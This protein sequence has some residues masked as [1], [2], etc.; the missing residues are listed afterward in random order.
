MKVS[1]QSKGFTLV[2]L[3][4]VIAII[5]LLAA[6]LF[7]VFNSVR[8]K[9]AQTVCL[10]NLKQLGSAIQMYVQDTGGFIPT[11]CISRNNP[12]NPPGDTTAPGQITWDASI[13]AYMK[14]SEIVKC[15]SNPNTNGKRARAY[16]IA[17]YTQRPVSGSPSTAWVPLRGCY[18][19]EIPAP[20]QT[21]LL[22]EKGAHLPTAWGDALGQ[23]VWE[24]TNHK[25]TEA[26]PG[27]GDNW[28]EAMYHFDGK[29]ILYVDGHAKFSQR[30]QYPFNHTSSRAGA[31]T[32]TV[33]VAGRQ[34][35]GGD[36]PAKQ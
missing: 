28:S 3:L 14:N 17:Q 27:D 24:T 33:W 26:P 16:S 36:W 1:A 21:V 20:S 25:Q 10:S 31:L 29:C 2:E 4:T 8:A 23:N 19:D 6:I 5:A 30:G 7:P 11:W 9:G 18:I 34:A 35:D 15:A 32:G 22:F 13:M 12:A